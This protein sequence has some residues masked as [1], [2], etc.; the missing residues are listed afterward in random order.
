MRFFE[1][2]FKKKTMKYVQMTAIFT[3]THHH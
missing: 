2:I 1:K 3:L